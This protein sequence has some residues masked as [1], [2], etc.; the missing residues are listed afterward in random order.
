[1]NEIENVF[2]KNSFPFS[3]FKNEINFKMIKLMSY[4]ST[5][6]KVHKKY[7]KPF[8]DVHLDAKNLMNFTCLTLKFHN[9]HH[10]NKG[11]PNACGARVVRA[12]RSS[13]LLVGRSE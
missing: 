8:E 12:A 4:D 7:Q 11:N 13:F 3:I 6:S 2:D 5:Y 1:M 10:A 9:C